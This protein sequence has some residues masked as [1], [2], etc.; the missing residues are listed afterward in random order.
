MFFI[1]SLSTI[2]PITPPTE[3]LTYGS[4]VITWGDETITFE[5]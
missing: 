3:G 5:N 4:M 1:F 2:E